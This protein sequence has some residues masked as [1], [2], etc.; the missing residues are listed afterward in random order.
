MNGLETANEPHIRAM[1]HDKP[2]VL[3]PTQQK[4]LTRWAI[5]KAMVL[6]G[7]SK[8]RIPFYRQCER[9]R[10]KPPSS[11]VPVGSVAWIGQLSVEGFHAGLTDTFGQIN[12][13]P[14]AFHS[15]VT[16]LIVGHLAIQVLTTHV[17]PMFSVHPIRPN[18]KPGAW[19][20]NL[21]NIWPVFGN[22]DWPPPV[23]FTLKG[24]DSIGALVNR[25]KIGTDIG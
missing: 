22:A 6:D 21:L 19:D 8:R 20:V 4:L 11:C 17:L 7:S 3:G 12:N 15:C 24:D 13:V 2:I 9:N 14:K 5:L 10:I 23:S 18:C 16:T 25:W 1:M